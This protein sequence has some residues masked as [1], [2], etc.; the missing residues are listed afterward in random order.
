M[1]VGDVVVSAITVLLPELWLFPV[2]GPLE[3]EA[4]KNPRK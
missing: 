1:S 4:Q 2:A 3:T